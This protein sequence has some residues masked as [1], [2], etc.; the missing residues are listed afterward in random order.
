M[1]KVFTS[2][3]LNSPAFKCNPAL[4]LITLAERGD[5]LTLKELL[6]L[7][8]VV[9]VSC[10]HTALFTGL[11]NPE[12]LAY[13]GIDTEAAMGGGSGVVGLHYALESMAEV[14]AFLVTKYLSL[15]EGKVKE[16]ENKETSGEPSGA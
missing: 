8:T 1:S 9:S 11:L 10:E 7:G 13:P 3:E 15:L 2:E 5:K 16:L 14:S 4:V 6:D 12:G